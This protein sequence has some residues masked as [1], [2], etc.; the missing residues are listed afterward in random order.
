MQELLKNLQMLCLMTNN[1]MTSISVHH[2]FVNN[3]QDDIITDNDG[4]FVEG[5]GGNRRSGRKNVKKSQVL[6][7]SEL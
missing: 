1:N 5:T 7:Q 4:S 3:T 6:S 2:T